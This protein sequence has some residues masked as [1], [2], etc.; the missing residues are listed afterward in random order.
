MRT[1]V[2]GLWL[3][4]G[5]ELREVFIDGDGGDED[6]HHGHVVL[7]FLLRLLLLVPSCYGPFAATAAWPN[8]QKLKA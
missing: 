2:R 1:W 7:P 4:Q 3:S 8:T 6:D 5:S